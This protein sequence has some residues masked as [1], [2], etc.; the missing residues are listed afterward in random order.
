MRQDDIAG[1]NETE[2]DPVGRGQRDETQKACEPGVWEG[3]SDCGNDEGCCDEPAVRAAVARSDNSRSICYNRKESGRRCGVFLSRSGASR[4]RLHEPALK[5][6]RHPRHA[7]EASPGPAPV[8]HVHA[9][10]IGEVLLMQINDD[11]PFKPQLEPLPFR[12]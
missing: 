7:I 1:K 5:V 6:A 3:Y 4:R 10:V 12:E 11:Q 8:S 2:R 9:K